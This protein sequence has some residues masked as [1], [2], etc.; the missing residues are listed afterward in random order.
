[1]ANSGAWFIGCVAFLLSYPVELI[2]C[3]ASKERDSSKNHVIAPDGYNIGRDWFVERAIEGKNWKGIWWK[4]DLEWR[5]G[6][7]SPGRKG[8]TT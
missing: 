7:L 2:R 4:A 8:R 6:L 5:E 3:R 1:M